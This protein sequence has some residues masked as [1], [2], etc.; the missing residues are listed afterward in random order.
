VT[1]R[2]IP[3]P[4]PSKE[5]R[6]VTGAINHVTSIRIAVLGTDCAIGK[7]TTA[8]VLA[9]ALNARGVKTVLVGTGQTGLRQGARFG[10]ALD[11]VPPQFCCGELEG[12]VV[13]AFEAER[14]EVIVIEGQEALSHPA[15]CTSAFILRGSQPDAV[16]L[17]HAPKRAHRCDFPAMS[18]PNPMAEIALIEAFA[19]TKVIGLTLNHENMDEADITAAISAFSRETDLP[20]T[21]ALCRPTDDL[22]AMVFAAFPALGAQSTAPAA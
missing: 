19:D 16:I 13:A 6:L 15:F 17:Q 1:A 9:N 20:V 21:D 10:V 14:P 3:K 7:R 11:A 12:A 2:D 22:L 5:L 8:T 4:R 18:M